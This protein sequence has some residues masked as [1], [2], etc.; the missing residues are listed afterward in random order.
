MHA[1]I[2]DF[3]TPSF[4]GLAQAVFD[5]YAMFNSRGNV[6]RAATPGAGRY[7]N[8]GD[9]SEPN[10]QQSFFG[11]KYQKLLEIKKKRGPRESFGR[12]RR[13]GVRLGR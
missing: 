8:E 12:R 13:W 2:F 1:D 6:I 7:I 5:D 4:R 9:V 3:R 10:W 11:D